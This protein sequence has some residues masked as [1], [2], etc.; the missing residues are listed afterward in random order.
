MNRL[1]RRDFLKAAGA[2]SLSLAAALTLASCGGKDQAAPQDSAPA[3][4]ASKPDNA[5]DIRNTGTKSDDLV[6]DESTE[7]GIIDEVKIGMSFSFASLTPFR[8]TT[9][10]TPPS[11]STSMTVWLIWTATITS[12]RRA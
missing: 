4:D 1:S 8:N 5:E 11:S 6:A 12:T 2:G 9:P 7:T 3:P 10:S